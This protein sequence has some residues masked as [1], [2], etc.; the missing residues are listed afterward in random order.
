MP[1]FLRVCVGDWGGAQVSDVAAVAGSVAES[2]TVAMSSTESISISLEPTASTDDLPIALCVPNGYGEIVVRVNIRGN[3]WARLAFQFAHE[4]CHVLADVPTWTVD[5][6][7]WLE[8]PLCETASLFALRHMAANW[9][10]APPYPQWREYSPSLA[11]YASDRI[12]D[13]TSSL[14][15]DRPISDWLGEHLPSLEADPYRRED[16]VIVAKEL[17]PIFE[18]DNH[19][20]RSIRYLHAAERLRSLELRDFVTGWRDA[21]PRENRGSVESIGA[22][23]GLT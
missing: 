2:F 22:V 16:N 21:C 8:E 7:S 12:S 9:L 4:F 15:P 20:W 18:S 1:I 14:P 19:A 5:R 3:L 13:P 10:V 11:T 23:L 6:F 17:L